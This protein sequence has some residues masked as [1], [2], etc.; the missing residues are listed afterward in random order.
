MPAQRVA[1]HQ[2]VIAERNVGAILDAA[3]DVLAARGHATMSAV[4]KRAGVSRVTLYSHFATW[5]A[6][7]EAAVARAVGRTMAAIQV[8]R[9]DEGPA[10]E[11]MDR[12]LAASWQHLARYSAMAQ[13]VAEQLDPEAVTRTH[14]TAHETIGR[15]VGRGQAEGTFRTD[16]PPSWLVTACIALVH[17]CASEVRAGRIAERDALGILT[18][19][20]RGLLTEPA[21][22]DGQSPA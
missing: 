16:V 21:L 9:P 22:T 17:S 1:E 4:A 5:E 3:E 14:R 19:T 8:A 7:L 18:A 13:A 12:T 15:I 10:G 6:L 20:I 11:A 2:R